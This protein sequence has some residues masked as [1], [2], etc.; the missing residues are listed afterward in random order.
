MTLPWER[1]DSETPVA[2]AAFQVYRDLAAERTLAKAAAALGKGH[3]VMEKWSGEH[4]WVERCLAWDRHLD[5]QGRRAA[6]A[7]VREM[8]ERHAREAQELQNAA[9]RD[10]GKIARR[11]RNA[12]EEELV[13]TPDLVLRYVEI[14]ARIERTARGEP[15]SIAALDVGGVDPLTRAIV[16]DEDVR[17]AARELVRRAAAARRNAEE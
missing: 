7:A 2:F 9:V 8:A 15:D 3:S 1:R 6:V 11:Q 5:E 16:G 4:D 12:G 13:L 14:G 10:L 17:E